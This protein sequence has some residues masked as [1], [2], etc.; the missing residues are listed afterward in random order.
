MK[1]RITP[2]LLS[3]V[4]CLL[5]C[6]LATKAAAQTVS[7]V[8][9]VTFDVTFNPLPTS[10]V[11]TGLDPSA[12]TPGAHYGEGFGGTGFDG[13]GS[14]A[15]WGA[16]DPF[17]Y[18]GA[19]NDEWAGVYNGGAIYDYATPQTALTIL[20]G[21]TDPSN[22][23]SFFGSEGNLIGTIT[24]QDI[25]TAIADNP[26]VDPNLDLTHSGSHE[27]GADVT[28]QIDPQSFSSVEVSGSPD[29]TFEYAY[30]SSTPTPSSSSVPDAGSTSELMFLSLAG[31]AAL[32]RRF[33]K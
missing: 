2:T 15:G 12:I 29:L 17:D 18:A 22:A 31:L 5:L 27:Y 8:D 30:V 28:I 26:S 19:P 6:G 20:W 16:T 21:T 25:I 10:G 11:T 33:A 4:A 9:G 32:R 23:L 7:V 1:S 3:I 13:Y 24:G 14:A